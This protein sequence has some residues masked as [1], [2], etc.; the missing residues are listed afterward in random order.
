MDHPQSRGSSALL[1]SRAHCVLLA[2]V[3]VCLSS[4]PPP[5]IRLHIASSILSLSAHPIA[6]CLFSILSSLASFHS[7]S[8]SPFTQATHSAKVHMVSF[9]CDGC[10]DTVKKPQTANHYQRCRAPVSCL[11]CQTTFYTPPEIQKHTSCISEVCL[12]LP[13]FSFNSLPLYLFLRHILCIFSFVHQYLPC[14]FF[15]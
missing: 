3:H 7:N 9:V 13:L 6:N 2:Q 4:Y 10:G 14:F 5:L 12:P 1:R 11:D 8:T 15:I